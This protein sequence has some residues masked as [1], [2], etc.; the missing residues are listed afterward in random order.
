M[1]QEGEKRS[2]ISEEEEREEERNDERMKEKG[3]KRGKG[4]RIKEEGNNFH[5]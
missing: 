3:W 4:E 2:Q 1:E 5:L